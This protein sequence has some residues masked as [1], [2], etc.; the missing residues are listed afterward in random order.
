MQPVALN[1]SCLR[2]FAR[3][4]SFTFGL[5]MIALL[6]L[7]ILSQILTER[8]AGHLAVAQDTAN[9]TRLVGENV[10]RSF[11]EVDRILQFL[12]HSYELSNFSANWIDLVND[13]YLD[14]QLILQL[15]VIDAQGRLIATNLQRTK[16][17]PVSIADREYFRVHVDASSDE[18]FISTPVLGRHSKRW[19]VHFTRRFVNKDGTFAGILIA[20]LDPDH[21]AKF[22]RSINFGHGGTVSLIGLDGIVRGSGGAHPF[23]LGSDVSKTDIF[24]RVST[25]RSGTLR[26]PDIKGI[27]GQVTSYRILRE[28]PVSI[29]VTADLDQPKSSHIRNSP[30][31]LAAAAGLT[32]L[33]LIAMS[34][35]IRHSRRFDEAREA[36]ASSEAHLRE[37]TSQL[38]LTLTHMSQGI[39]MVDAKGNIPVINPRC[40]EMLGIPAGKLPLGTSHERL[41]YHELVAALSESGEFQTSSS[42]VEPDVLKYI[43]RSQV[44][45]HLSVYERTRPDGM[46]L[47]VRSNALPDGGFVRTFNDITGRRR[48]EAKIV[49]MASH[50]PLTDLANRV[51][52]REEL[53]EAVA[54]LE[55]NNEC[56]ALHL[57]DLDHFKVVND[58][59]GHPIG[60]QLLRDVAR[61]LRN[62]VR[63][64][65]IIARLGGDEFAVI[66]MHLATT[67]QA[68]VL[69]DRLCKMMAH[70]FQI[71]GNKLLIGAS[72]GVAIAPNDG[73]ASQ[74]LLKA[75]DLALYTAKA[76]VRSTYRFFEPEMNNTLQARRRLDADLR[77]ALDHKEFAIHYQPIINLR[78][79][80]VTGYEALIRWHHPERGLIS[81]AEFIPAAEANGLIVPIGAWTLKTACAEIARLRDA[82]R[83]AVNVSPVQLRS[84]NFLDD[85]LQA[86]AASGLPAN[87]LEIE[88]TESALLDRNDRT[89]HQLQALYELGIHIALDDFGTG[90]S[91]LSYL[92]SYP[93]SSIKIDR[94]FVACLGKGKQSTSIIRA[95]TDLASN[96][97]MTT[98]AEGVETAEQLA[99]LKQLGCTEAQG[100]YFS[101]PRPA[102]Q[103]FHEIQTLTHDACAEVA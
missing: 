45:D 63:S 57:L 11:S 4:P 79:Q 88:I 78:S 30:F 60:D 67:A 13:V 3:N 53:E 50:D 20:A 70:P 99:K 38:E 72:V 65:D 87:R 34:A 97:A 80:Q 74:D 52:F 39:L 32:L 27:A 7:A 58:S 1:F 49:H 89:I 93:I 21:F 6:W 41:T 71:D 51:L 94:S 90:Y 98:T 82:P 100:F 22:Y 86:L 75:A 10:I 85:V 69:A 66:Q 103:L 26:E 81:P 24:Q 73:S 8:R 12:R 102:S 28:Y 15:A 43:M 17:N 46:V 77:M 54:K 42:A 19:S 96:L 14:H 5:A 91:S 61:R 29:V 2:K 84:P 36:L 23:K 92:M 18:L 59:H 83:I 44:S 64:G 76:E 9:L 55:R 31:Y 33:I 16:P 95:I 37:K 35:S 68:G 47:E 62:S 40:I 25:S 56:F 101:P 48:N